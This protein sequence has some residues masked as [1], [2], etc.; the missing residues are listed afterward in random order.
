MNSFNVSNGVKQGGVIFPLLFSCYIDTFF[1]QIE[2]SGLGCHVGT[3]YAG[4]F[5]YA[6]DIALVAPSMQCLEKMIIICEK[7]ANSHSITF[8]PNKLKLMCFNVDDTDVIPQTYLNGKVIPVVDSD[9]HLGNYIS[10]NIT[11]RNIID[12]I[13]DLY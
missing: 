9:E 11:D 2:H 7:Y 5:G 10:T 13:C 12:N 4:A 6:D 3:S 8:N 1:S